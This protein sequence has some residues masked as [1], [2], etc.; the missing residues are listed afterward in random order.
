MELDEMIIDLMLAVKYGSQRVRPNEEGYEP[1]IGGTTIRIM[2]FKLQRIVIIRRE[3]VRE[4]INHSFDLGQRIV[5]YLDSK[6]GFGPTRYAVSLSEAGAYVP[7]ANCLSSPAADYDIDRSLFVWTILHEYMHRYQT[8]IG[9][10]LAIEEPRN[11]NRVRFWHGSLHVIEQSKLSDEDYGKLP[12]EAE[13]DS[14]ANTNAMHVCSHFNIEVA[15]E[16]GPDNMQLV[17][18]YKPNG[19]PNA[20]V[21]PIHWHYKSSDGLNVV[22]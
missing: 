21:E 20:F 13:A 22:R 15:K 6:T 3:Y 1:V 4:F 19:D 5:D 12:W 16:V 10:Y 11:G 14:F 17:T 9:K 7:G 2:D 8:D 18:R